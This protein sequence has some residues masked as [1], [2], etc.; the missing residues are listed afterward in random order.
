M[1]DMKHML[2]LDLKKHMERRLTEIIKKL[3]QQIFMDTGKCF[4]TFS[5]LSNT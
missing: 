1:K 3:I 4:Y 5:D 2:I